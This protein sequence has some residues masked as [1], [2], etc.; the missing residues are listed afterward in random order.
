MENPIRIYDAGQVTRYHAQ[1]KLNRIL[2]TNADHSWGVAAI[3]CVLY[4]M[5]PNYRVLMHALFHDIGER[6]VGDPPADFKRANPE[7]KALYK[8]AELEASLGI[9]GALPYITE[10]EELVLKFADVV[11]AILFIC[12]HHPD[13]SS[14]EGW[15]GALKAIEQIAPK[16][17]HEVDVAHFIDCHLAIMIRAHGFYF[18][19]TTNAQDNEIPF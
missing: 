12:E 9:V 6:I 1:P 5:E 8:E 13:P 15:P 2:Q 14:V 16:I 17:Q 7:L 11:E 4:D 19:F 10:T 18:E 3:V